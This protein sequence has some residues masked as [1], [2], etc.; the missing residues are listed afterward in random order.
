MKFLGCILMALTFAQCKT[1]KFDKNP[2]FTIT[3]ATYNNWVG[4]QP[5]VSGIKVL[6]GYT[7]EKEIVFESVYFA[8][9]TTKAESATNEGKT[10]I[11]GNIDTSTRDKE[12]TLHS[13]SKEELNNQLPEK[14]FPFELQENEAVVSYKDGDKTKYFKIE[15]LK[16][17]KTDYY[18]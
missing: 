12:L 5:G 8:N 3:G 16:Q 14:K 2:P 1:M 11:V 6:I 15:N 18:P 10:Y 17:T 4:G 9:K 7:S 13:D